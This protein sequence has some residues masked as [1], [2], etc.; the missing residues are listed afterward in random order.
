MP[1][2][3]TLYNIPQVMKEYQQKKKKLLC[4]QFTI[5]SVWARWLEKQTLFH[6]DKLK[7]NL[8]SNIQKIQLLRKP[9][10]ILNEVKY[11]IW[12]IKTLGNNVYIRKSSQQTF[13]Y[14]KSTIETLKNKCEICSKLTIKTARRLY[15]HFIVNFEYIHSF[16]LRS[17]VDLESHPIN[18]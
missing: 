3:N 1:F 2:C 6:E 5:L 17:A 10:A 4:T 7:M 16:S 11:S 9:V 8:Q 12:V 14:S 18:L 13:T 15:T